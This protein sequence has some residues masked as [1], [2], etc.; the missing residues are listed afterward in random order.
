MKSS[1]PLISFAG[2]KNTG[3][4]TLITRLVEVFA[5]RGLRI[6]C[7]KH[8]GHD[9]EVQSANTDTGKYLTAGA[10]VSLIASHTGNVLA[11]WRKEAEPSLAELINRLGKV[12]LIM[13]EG[14]KELPIPKWVL[15]DSVNENKEYR[16]PDFVKNAD[17]VGHI[18]GF[19]VPAAPLKVADTNLPVYH[20][21]NIVDIESAIDLM[22]RIVHD[23]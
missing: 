5:T 20:R 1:V 7:I 10:S 9:F 16:I 18:V 2:L 3:K 12:D 19:I 22:M 17:I 11:Q 8:D 13:V 15:L 6:G 4:T 14:Y 21:D 23:D